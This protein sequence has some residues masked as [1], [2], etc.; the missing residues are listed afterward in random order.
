MAFGAANPWTNTIRQ[1]KQAEEQHS[2]NVKTFYELIKEHKEE[3]VEPPLELVIS[4][5][6]EAPLEEVEVP[7][8]LLTHHE[9][10]Q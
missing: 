2:T 9:E 3:K 4:Q 7:P 8:P 1:E 5:E 10:E 6:E